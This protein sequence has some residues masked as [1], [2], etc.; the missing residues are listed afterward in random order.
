MLRADLIFRFVLFDS[1]K[2]RDS[3]L[4]HESPNWIFRAKALSMTI[5]GVDLIF[6]DCHDLA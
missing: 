4:I 6:L 5:G 3:P 1:L 2:V